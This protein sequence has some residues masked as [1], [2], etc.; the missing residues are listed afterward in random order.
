MEKE[1]LNEELKELKK[2]RDASLLMLRLVA[3]N[4]GMLEPKIMIKNSEINDNIQDIVSL[5]LKENA[6]ESDKE[7]IL[8]FLTDV[9]AQSKAFLK[10]IKNI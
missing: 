3:E 10:N 8:E 5:S 2:K 6:L 4:T 9:E 1:E 7:Q